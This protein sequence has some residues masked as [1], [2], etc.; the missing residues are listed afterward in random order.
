MRAKE[1]F[2]GGGAG[3][4]ATA[5]LRWRAAS[6]ADTGV[7]FAVSVRFSFPE[8]TVLWA[9]ENPRG[10]L[11]SFRGTPGLTGVVHSLEAETCSHPGRMQ[12]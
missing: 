5:D 12:T 6:G 8:W 7:Q 9:Q 10:H 4:D 1:L 2:P 3:L 11:L